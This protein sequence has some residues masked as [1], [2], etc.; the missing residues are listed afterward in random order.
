MNQ[1]LRLLSNVSTKYNI[2]IKIVKSKKY[3]YI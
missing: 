3:E 2:L 1:L